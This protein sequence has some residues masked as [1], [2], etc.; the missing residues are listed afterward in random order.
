MLDDEAVLVLAT[1][2]GRVVV[3]RNIRDFAELA[4]RWNEDARAHAGCICIATSIAG[5][6]E[7]LEAISR[8]LAEQEPA[9]AWSGLL[10]IVGSA[11]GR[12]TTP[13]PDS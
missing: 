12:S 11:D 6:G 3:T 4:R 1:G 5:I 7:T 10:V 2:E 8:A 13:T 9:R